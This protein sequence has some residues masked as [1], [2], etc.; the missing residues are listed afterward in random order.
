MKNQ[1]SLIKCVHGVF[2]GWIAPQPDFVLPFAKSYLS[3]PISE[4]YQYDPVVFRSLKF[5]LIDCENHSGQSGGSTELM[6]KMNNDNV[7][8]KEILFFMS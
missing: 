4:S 8:S 3:A 7:I 2:I 5:T 1:P 6:V